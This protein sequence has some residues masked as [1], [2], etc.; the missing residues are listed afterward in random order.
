M[1][2]SLFSQIIP[3]LVFM[4]LPVPVLKAIRYLLAGRP[5]VHSLLMIVTWG[6]IF[7]LVL[8]MAV[9][10]KS[11]LKDMIEINS[12]YVSS[13]DLSG[14]MHLVLGLVLV[15]IGV[16]KLQLGLQQGHAPVVQKSIDV[17]PYSII[18]TTIHTQL[19]SIKNAL[20]MFLIIYLL[21]KS[22]AGLERGLLV[23][24]IIAL[25]S[26]IWIAMPL[27]VYLIAGH[28]RDRILELL[29]AWLIHNKD[30]LIIFIYLFIGISTLSSGLGEL[31]P[32]LLEDLFVEV[33]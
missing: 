2:Q 24:G 25:M 8:S 20:L 16:K 31:I 13:K 23:S 27:F 12:T 7:Y 9:I 15:T 28:D 21:F 33:V 14:W 22:E 1:T 32:K 17:T 4:A 19:F 5:V 3:L 10:L 29:K 6:I 18:R 11:F 26:M 30:T